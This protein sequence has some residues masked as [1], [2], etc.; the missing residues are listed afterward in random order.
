M[1]HKAAKQSIKTT[2]A[3]YPA[4]FCFGTEE[5]ASDICLSLAKIV[6][7]IGMVLVVQ[8]NGTIKSSLRTTKDINLIPIAKKLGGNGHPF[9]AAFPCSTEKLI[10]ILER[11]DLFDLI[12]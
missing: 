8:S 10:F 5:T 3:G 1:V 6:D 9:A 11:K 2:L 4:A 7:G 12:D